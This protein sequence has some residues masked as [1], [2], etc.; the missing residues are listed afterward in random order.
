MVME[1]AKR[2]PERFGGV[3]N[4]AYGPKFA[5]T[6]HQEKTVMIPLGAQRH[7]LVVD[8]ALAI[9]V[10]YRDLL[11]G[12]GYRV[13]ALGAAPNAEAIKRI[14][15][16]LLLCDPGVAVDGGGWELLPRLRAEPETAALPV[17]VCTGDVRRVREEGWRLAYPDVELVLKPFDVDELRRAV[18]GLLEPAPGPPVS[19]RDPQRGRYDPASGLALIGVDAADRL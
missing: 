17:V 1:Q 16:D 13:S 9:R 11:E 18:H 2:R 10:L 15:P 8:D 6:E 4:A 14:G 19:R 12:E 7:I 5:P 3:A